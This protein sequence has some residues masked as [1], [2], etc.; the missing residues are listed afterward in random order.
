LNTYIE[1]WKADGD[2]RLVIARHRLAR[3]QGLE[4]KLPIYLLAKLAG[5]YT[6]LDQDDVR[7]KYQV[8]P[9]DSVSGLDLK[10][11]A[12][13]VLEIL[14]SR[15]EKRD[16]EVVEGS[17]YGEGFYR[18]GMYL[19]S[20]KESQRALRQFQNAHQYDPHHYLAI[21]AMGE[22]YKSIKDYGRAE[23]YFS[24]AVKTYKRYHED[25]GVRPEDETLEQGDHAKLY[26]N[27]GS[28]VFLRYAGLPEESTEG[29][30]DTRI[31]PDRAVRPESPD[32][33]K[34]R[35]QLVS[36]REYFQTALEEGVKD[37]KAKLDSIFWMGWIDYV[38]ADFTGALEQ[39][40]TMDTG[41]AYTD[42][43]LMMGKANAYFYTDQMR[44]ALG[45][46][47]KIESDLERESMIIGRPDPSN[48]KHRRL[49]L[50][51]A[52]VYNNIGAIYE[53]EYLESAK[54]GLPKS[55]LNTLEK[56]ALLNY[57]HAVEAARKVELDNEVA[58][59]NI[60]LAFKA[61][62]QTKEHE[63]LLDDWV[64]PVLTVTDKEK[65]R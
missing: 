30:R 2:P 58:R 20:Q 45:S 35:E 33:R 38:S 50:N 43:V 34:R 53:R 65:K 62:D 9:V 27:L 1:I 28:L 4:D 48:S 25:Y 12:A 64:P 8:D 57:W 17:H 39:W 13:K 46:Y 18:R 61:L 3:A 14:F 51:L 26:Y 22:Y 16:E 56:N 10:D 42:P 7:I 60:Q 40:E 47:L 31:Y 55:S 21:N 6:E 41:V 49:Y 63:P 36:S 54:R 52:A 32:M 37:E 15:K 23:Q 11:N 59:S 29:F 19:L 24:E 44:T 5:F